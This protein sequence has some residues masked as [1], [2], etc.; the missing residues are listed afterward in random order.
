VAKLGGAGGNGSVTAALGD[1]LAS[2]TSRV[3]VKGWGTK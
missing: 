3:D 2:M 1:G